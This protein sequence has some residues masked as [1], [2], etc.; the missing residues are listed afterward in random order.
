VLDSY[1]EGL[2]LSQVAIH[3]APA[4]LREAEARLMQLLK[5]AEKTR[6]A[7]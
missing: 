4:G 1:R 2:T 3:H 5:R 7:A 6:K